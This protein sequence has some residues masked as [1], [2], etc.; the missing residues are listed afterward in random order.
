MAR[1]ENLPPLSSY[2]KEKILMKRRFKPTPFGL[3]CT[4]KCC[5][6]AHLEQVISKSVSVVI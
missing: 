3:Y 4:P 5:H 2:I 1:D 6:R